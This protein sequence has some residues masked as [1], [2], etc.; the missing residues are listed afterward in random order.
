MVVESRDVL[1]RP[2][3]PPD[4]TLRYGPS[5]DQIV[6]LRRPAAVSGPPAAVSAPPVVVIHGGFW[7]PEW[8]RS[9]TGP[10]AAALAELGYPVAQ[11]EYRRG[12]G[13]PAMASDVEAGVAAVAA[14]FGT[15]ILLG[16]SAGGQLALWYAGRSASAT[17]GAGAGAVGPAGAG[18]GAAG[19]AGAGGGAGPACL[20]VVALAPVA[21]LA[22]AH[23]LD[24]DDGAV[25][26]LFGDHPF[27]EADPC[28]RVPI[29]LP[30]VVVHG[31]ADRFVPIDLSRRF[32][33]RDHA[34][35]GVTSLVE[36]PHVGHFS[37]IDPEASTWEYITGPLRTIH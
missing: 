11:L 24:L 12:A 33:A 22:E 3:P 17:G 4:E 15:P 13:W 27:D 20:G 31:V 6:D 9:H 35:G 36:L 5:A 2:S 10:M 26:D 1:S 37:L 7:R 19:P 18:G 25:A 8:D 30:C 32:V 29:Q 28:H 14:R 34:A 23:R 16:H 21:D